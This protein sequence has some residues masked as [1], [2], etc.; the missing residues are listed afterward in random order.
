[1][2]GWSWVQEEPIKMILLIILSLVGSASL[3]SLPTFAAPNWPIPEGVKTIEINGYDMAYKESGSGV[4]IVLI[5]GLVS[6]YRSWDASVPDFSKTYRT[7]AVSL[8]H[9][10][11]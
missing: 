8:R 11:P 9:N 4:P 5:H 10:Y 1:M 3:P 6:D 7:I 2:E